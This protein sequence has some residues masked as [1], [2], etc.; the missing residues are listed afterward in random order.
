MVGDGARAESSVQAVHRELRRAIV[1]GVYHPGAPLRLQV[2]AAEYGVSFI[3]V[4]EA[5]RMLEVEGLVEIIPN[6]GARVAPLSLAAVEDVYSTRLALEINAL[7]RGFDHITPDI[8]QRGYELI[9]Q[10]VKAFKRGD[11][12]AYEFHRE[13]HF[14]LYEASGSR[15]LIQMISTLWDHTDRYRRLSMPLN[16]DIDG[17]GREHEAIFAAIEK[18]DRDAASAALRSHLEHTLAMLRERVSQESGS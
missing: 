15:W 7:R 2:L 13:L 1:D 12:R 5:L 11:N 14:L 4:R 6:R 18:G 16:E 3:P 8:V 17:L 9:D 10:I